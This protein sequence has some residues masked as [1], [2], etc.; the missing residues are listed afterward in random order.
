M[1][2]P[3]MGAGPS[4]GAAAGP[5]TTTYHPNSTNCVGWDGYDAAGPPATLAMDSE[6]ALSGAELTT[7]S[8]DDTNFLTYAG[9]NGQYLGCHIR[10]AITEVPADVTQID[11]LAKGYGM[12][13]APPPVF[14]YGLYIWD[15]DGTSWELMDSHTLNVS[16]TVSDSVLANF[17]NYIHNITGTNYIDILLL[18]G[19]GNAMAGPKLYT[20]YVELAVTG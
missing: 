7:S 13:W 4:A 16:G 2:M 20:Y 1:S 3:L 15:A 11:V 14:S 10:I 8:V 5:S 17:T 18:G 9:T 19:L 6:A 12:H